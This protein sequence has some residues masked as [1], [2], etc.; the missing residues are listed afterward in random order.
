MGIGGIGMCGLAELLYN[1]GC[2]VTGSD[3]QNS[4]QV[5]RLNK[6]GIPISI[7]HSPLNVHETTDIVIYSSA[8]TEDNVELAVAR[9][10]GLA[11]IRRAEALAEMMRLKRGIVVAGTHGKTTTTALLASVFAFAEKDPTVVAG[12]RLDLFQSTARLGNS[13][14]FIAESDESDGSFLHLYPE[15][16]VLTNIEDDHVD[17]YGSFQELK[18]NF[19]MF[20]EKIPFYGALIACGDCPHVL[21]V[22]GGGRFSK[23]IWFYGLNE[24]NDFVLKE[25][26]E[27]YAV[28]RGKEKWATLETPLMGEYNA[29][30]SL[31]SL[32]CGWQAGIEKDTLLAG[33]KSFR[34]V[35]RRMELKG[36]HNGII[37]Y[38]DYAHHPTEVQA[39]LKA[40]KKQFP[41]NRKVVLFQPHRYTRFK[42]HWNTFLKSFSAADVLYVSDVYPASESP[43]KGVDSE[44][45]IQQLK[46]PKKYFVSERDMVSKICWALRPGDIFVTLGAGSVSRF[47]EEILSYLRA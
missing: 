33:L 16:A 29:L 37:F 40:L 15:L 22:I 21:E 39:A 38:D 11:V 45:F 17:F 43:L 8:V 20:L 25:E 26:Q 28:Y 47:G 31:A 5:R 1:L 32:V 18:K 9:E 41:D 4:T 19:L 35:Q 14:W 6:M 3:L 23:K 24:N 27:G 44:K 42:Y 34:G 36:R 2:R 12:G 7:G 13:E 30:N 10:R 46:H